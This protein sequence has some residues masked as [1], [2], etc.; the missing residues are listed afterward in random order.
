[1]RKFGFFMLFAI[2]MFLLPG[3]GGGGGGSNG[4]GS[5]SDG[6]GNGGSATEINIENI[7]NGSW[8]GSNG[9]GTASGPDGVFLLQMISC[10]GTFTK[11]NAT[12]TSG[13]TTATVSAIWDAYQ[14]GAF[15]RSIPLEY[16]NETVKIMRI[17]TNTWR[18]TFP[19][20]ESKITF[21]FTSE[22]TA[23]V[24]EEGNFGLGSYVYSYSATYTMT[25]Q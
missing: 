6:G 25:K 14:N 5:N 16:T 19:S 8:M 22:T 4:G 13:E 18:F 21:T 24:K 7:M 17:G 10:L 23:S 15:I 3:C 11:T 20:N 1:M 2:A 12:S 9:S